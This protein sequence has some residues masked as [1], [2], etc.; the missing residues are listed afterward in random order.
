MPVLGC[1]RVP[2]RRRCRAWEGHSSELLVLALGR[3]EDMR[4][5]AWALFFKNPPGIVCSLEQAE[6]KA[7]RS[8]LGSTGAAK[9]QFHIYFLTLQSME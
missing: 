8:I 3:G 2:G 7:G 1:E 9:M 4:T 5:L 6:Q